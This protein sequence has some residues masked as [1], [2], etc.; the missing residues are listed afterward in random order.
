MT[1][2]Y[3]KADLV[4][5]GPEPALGGP[6]A[7]LLVIAGQIDVFPPERGEIVE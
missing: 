5:E 4:A 6:F 2:E 1:P 3:A 7:T